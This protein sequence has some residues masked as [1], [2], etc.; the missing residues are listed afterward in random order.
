MNK[1]IKKY[2]MNEFITCR[3]EIRP[4]I[5]YHDNKQVCCFNCEQFDSCFEENL[6]SGQKVLPCT[7]DLFDREE[8]CEFVC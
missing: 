8:I 2:K 6:N 5:C 4:N 3:A 1:K 7:Q